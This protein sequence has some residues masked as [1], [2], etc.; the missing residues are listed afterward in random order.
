MIVAGLDAT[1]GLFYGHT[2]TVAQLATDDW[3]AGL[4]RGIIESQTGGAIHRSLLPAL[5]SLANPL[6]PVGFSEAFG[7]G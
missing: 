2:P 5:G 6:L 7:N 3:T 4:Y 1:L